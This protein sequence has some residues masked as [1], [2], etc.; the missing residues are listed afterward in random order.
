V[1]ADLLKDITDSLNRRAFSR[2]PEHF[3]MAHA[4]VE[5]FVK[6]WLL[7]QYG[8]PPDLPIYLRIAFRNEPGA[9]AIA[10]SN[11]AAASSTPSAATSSAPPALSV[12]PPKG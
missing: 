12:P 2:T 1:Q 5:K 10:S 6:D 4:G 8:L 9:P 11:P 7:Q 3:A